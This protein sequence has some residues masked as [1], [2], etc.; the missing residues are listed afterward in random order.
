MTE[1][2]SQTDDQS[3]SQDEGTRDGGDDTTET[4]VSFEEESSASPSPEEPLSGLTNRIETGSTATGES[5]AANEETTTLPTVQTHVDSE[6][7][8]KRRRSDERTTDSRQR[9]GPLGDLAS[10]IDEQ[11]DRSSEFD[12]LF[13]REDIGGIDSNRLWEQLENDGEF[14]LPNE[15][16]EYRVIPKRKYC[17]QCEHFATPPSVGCQ[18]EGTDILELASLD[19]FYVADCPVVLEDESL[20][21]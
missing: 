5:P 20:E 19:M 7:D 2:P 17:H 21:R 16:R 4:S 13:E 12:E 6:T 9:S 11:T 18:L 10:S 15:D 1:E 8:F 14:E 3:P